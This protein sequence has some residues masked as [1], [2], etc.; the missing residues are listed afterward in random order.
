MSSGF[1][2]G[3]VIFGG[4]KQAEQQQEEKKDEAQDDQWANVKR[5]LDEDRARREQEGKQE[6]G[7]SL[8]EILQQNKGRYSGCLAKA[9]ECLKK[10][11][12]TF[13]HSERM[14]SNTQFG[15]LSYF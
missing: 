12:K 6:N 8:Y 13:Q 3:G 4:E 10:K 14:V 7:K 9:I 1:S 15:L 5:E 2:S 11:K